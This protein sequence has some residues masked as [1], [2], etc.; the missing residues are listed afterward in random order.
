MILK[1]GIVSSVSN[2]ESCSLGRNTRIDRNRQFILSRTD[3]ITYELYSYCCIAE[4][5]FRIRNNEF[6]IG[7][8]RIVNTHVV[9][10]SICLC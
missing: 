4:S 6:F 8:K 7:K 2:H 5:R 10:G 9:M 1:G 3:L